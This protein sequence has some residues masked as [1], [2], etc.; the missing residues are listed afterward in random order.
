MKNQQIPQFIPIKN[1]AL[2][3]KE[4]KQFDQENTSVT[5]INHEIYNRIVDNHFRP[6]YCIIL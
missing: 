3:F 5:D 4:I 1:H 6:V 2:I